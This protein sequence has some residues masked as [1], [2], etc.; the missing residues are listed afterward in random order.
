MLLLVVFDIA[1]HSLLQRIE[2]IRLV[3]NGVITAATAVD[4]TIGSPVGNRSTETGVGS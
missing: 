4:G 3:G 2:R 1:G